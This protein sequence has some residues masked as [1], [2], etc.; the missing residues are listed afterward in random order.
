[1]GMLTNIFFLVLS[2]CAVILT[3][4][5]LRIERRREQQRAKQ[6]TYMMFEYK[7]S[8]ASLSQNLNE[9]GARGWELVYID[10]AAGMAY[11]KQPI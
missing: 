1:M 9:L 3:V 4:A 2:V 7:D 6:W 5:H 10:T 8:P 11:F